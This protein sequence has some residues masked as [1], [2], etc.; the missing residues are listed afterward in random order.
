MTEKAPWRVRWNFGVNVNVFS[1]S[2]TSYMNLSDRQLVDAYKRSYRWAFHESLQVLKE[3]QR[4]KTPFS[5][6]YALFT[7]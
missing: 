7:K 4:R 6:F 5:A 3:F 1:R 2:M